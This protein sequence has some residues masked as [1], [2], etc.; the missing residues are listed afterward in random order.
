MNKGCCFGKNNKYM[1]EGNGKN[2]M[3]GRITHACCCLDTT[4][5][6]HK[7]GTVWLGELPVAGHWGLGVKGRLGVQAGVKANARHMLRGLQAGQ[8]GSVPG[9]RSLACFW[10]G[11]KK[12]EGIRN[13]QLPSWEGTIS[14][15]NGEIII[16]KQ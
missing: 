7:P 13:E 1:L 3:K 12:G 15:N 16:Y 10:E 8:E 6:H 14:H 4:K 11:V 5:P 9:P 2:T